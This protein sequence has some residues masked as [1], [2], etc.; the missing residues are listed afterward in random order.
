[1]VIDNIYGNYDSNGNLIGVFRNSGDI[2]PFDATAQELED[3][4]CGGGAENTCHGCDPPI[5]DTLYVTFP[6]DLDGEFGKFAGNTYAVPW[7]D[8]CWWMLLHTPDDD[9]VVDIVYNLT[10]DV[11]EIMLTA[12]YDECYM[13]W[14][15]PIAYCDPRGTYSWDSSVCRCD[16]CNFDCGTSRGNATVAYS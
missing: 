8:G 12:G 14:E 7:V 9:D 16:D 13:G 15:G 11:W 6:T 3:C 5:P 1:M 2:A 10:D 4:C